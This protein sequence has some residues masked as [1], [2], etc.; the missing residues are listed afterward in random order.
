MKSAS[1]IAFAFL[2]MLSAET[3]A[4]SATTAFDGKWSVTLTKYPRL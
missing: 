4:A 3:K 2:T 1:L